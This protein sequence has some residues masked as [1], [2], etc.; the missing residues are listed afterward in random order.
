VCVCVAVVDLLV[1]VSGLREGA[2]NVRRVRRRVDQ[3]LEVGAAQV[4]RLVES[5]QYVCVRARH[6]C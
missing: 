5:S 4:L 6:C 2:E 1:G 3:L